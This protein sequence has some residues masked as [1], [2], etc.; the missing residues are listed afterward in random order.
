MIV[1]KTEPFHLDRLAIFGMIAAHQVTDEVVDYAMDLFGNETGAVFSGYEGLQLS[2]KG[3]RFGVHE[4]QLPGACKE[5]DTGSA[6][7]PQTLR[8]FSPIDDW[9]DY[10]FWCDERHVPPSLFS[11]SLSKH[12]VNSRSTSL[13]EVL[14]RPMIGNL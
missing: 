4:Q 9:P 2:G 7:L 13:I 3:L 12:S 10:V 11:R 14:H 5:N 8:L 6:L 1:G